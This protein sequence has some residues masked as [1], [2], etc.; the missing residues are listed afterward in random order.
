MTRTLPTDSAEFNA[1]MERVDAKLA[2]E[3]I[4]ITLRP[5]RALM[6]IGNEFDTPIPLAKPFPNIDPSDPIAKNWPFVQRANQWYSDRYGDRLLHDFRPG[7]VAFLLR[8]TPWVLHLPRIYGRAQTVASRTLKSER[9]RT[10][11]VPPIYNVLDGIKGLTEEL[12]RTLSD[13]ELREIFTLFQLGY[14]ALTTVE[15]LCPNGLVETGMADID[16][17]VG[18]IMARN[19]SYGQSRWASLQATEK[20]LKACIEL[21]GGK[22][23]LTH[24]LQ[25]ICEEASSVG[26]PTPPREDI[27]T[28]QCLASVRYGTG[29]S[30][31]SEA[32]NAHHASL[33][34]YLMAAEHVHKGKQIS[35]SQLK[36]SKEKAG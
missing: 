30:T 27:D 35:T 33:R 24:D 22:Y 25:K 2:S 11:G 4:P 34:I 26:I 1:L 7:R 20:I 17:A 8:Q 13:S 5:I 32:I 15:Y 21:K 31:L 10:D 16:A 9:F 14:N 29:A 19:P 6:A 12:R 3:G 23:S 28:I 18:H 36:E